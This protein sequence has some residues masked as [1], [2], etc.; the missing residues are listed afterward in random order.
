MSTHEK[1]LYVAIRGST[2]LNDFLTNA[3]YG[4]STEIN[5]SFHRGFY[6]SNRP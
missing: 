2:S 4:V 5:L 6:Y 3:E 1:D